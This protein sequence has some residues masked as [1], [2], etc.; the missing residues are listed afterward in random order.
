MDIQRILIEHKSKYFNVQHIGH[1]FPVPAIL[2]LLEWTNATPGPVSG[3]QAEYR[4][5][6]I[7]IS[8]GLLDRCP[9]HW[10]KSRGC[11]GEF[12]LK[13][14]GYNFMYAIPVTI[15]RGIITLPAGAQL[16]SESRSAMLVLDPL[17]HSN[18][19]IDSLEFD[20]QSLER[21]P[22]LEFL[23][24]EPDIYSMADVKPENLNPYFIN[25]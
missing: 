1:L 19:D 18:D 10:D 13:S 4:L 17:L 2:T 5:N 7:A 3:E 12:S 11:G 14:I 15:E 8:I 6:S 23:Q 24:S 25:R 22:S 9:S 21:N 16:P 20:L